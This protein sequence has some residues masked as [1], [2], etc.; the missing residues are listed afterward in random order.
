MPVEN[1]FLVWAAGG[2]SQIYTQSQ[3]AAL[4][5][6]GPGVAPG[7]AD[8]LQANKTW[9]QTSVIASVIAQFIVANSGQPAIDD[10]TTATL[11]TN[12]TAS[13]NALLGSAGY[14]TT[15][16]LSSEAATRAAADTALTTNLAN[17]VTR[18]E[19]AEVTK[20]PL[21]HMGINGGSSNIGGPGV[22]TSSTFT[23]SFN[24]IL[25]STM[26]FACNGTETGIV[27]TVTGTGVANLQSAG[28]GISAGGSGIALNFSI[29]SVTAGD[30]V[31]VTAGGGSSTGT[32][33]N[34]NVM[35]FLIPTS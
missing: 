19:A 21:A 31:T 26:S 28:N 1:D 10:G 22:F 12:F 16:A 15:S 32:S 9:R 18:A 8:P 17:E 13:I 24:G 5:T 34:V 23:P 2:T 6:L 20:V 11:L 7:I 29:S 14:A 4:P 27:F 35:Y 25:I 3:Y 33:G 30:A